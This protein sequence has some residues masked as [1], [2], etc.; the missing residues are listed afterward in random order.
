MKGLRKKNMEQE[1][2]F[3]IHYPPLFPPT[4]FTLNITPMALR[5][6]IKESKSKF[7]AIYCQFERYGVWINNSTG[8]RVHSDHWNKKRGLPKPSSAENQRLKI[9]LEEAEQSLEAFL[10]QKRTK[11]AITQSMERIF[12]EEEITFFSA[13]GDYLIY[14]EER[15]SH[16]AFK[17]YRI[18]MHNPQT[19]EKHWE[20]PITFEAIGGSLWGG[21]YP[22]V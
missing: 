10:S 15:H 14:Q 20:K 21:S 1:G 6:Y 5:C 8:L 4:H 7:S 16:A 13:W 22:L 18:M 3:F 9:K 19:F 11:E 12:L 2:V 17:K